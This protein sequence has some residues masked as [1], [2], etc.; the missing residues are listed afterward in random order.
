[1]ELPR[2][3]ARKLHTYCGRKLSIGLQDTLAA[4]N[5]DSGGCSG[6]LAYASIQHRFPMRSSYARLSTH[7]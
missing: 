6:S 5:P 3:S 2:L 7:A 4:V 1:M